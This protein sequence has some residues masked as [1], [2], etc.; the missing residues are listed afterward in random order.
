MRNIAVGQQ[1]MSK[2]S[3]AEAQL[4]VYKHTHTDSSH[5]CSRYQLIG[6]TQM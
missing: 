5:I 1:S 6:A 4:A 3:F 2:V